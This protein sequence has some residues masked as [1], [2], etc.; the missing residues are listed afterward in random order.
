MELSNPL[1]LYLSS[2][3]ERPMGMTS[4][5][6]FVRPFSHGSDQSDLTDL[7]SLIL[8]DVNFQFSLNF[9]LRNL[10]NC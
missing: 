8:A 5:L 7:T 4:P 1:A 6:Q 9:Q 3:L 10:I 2:W